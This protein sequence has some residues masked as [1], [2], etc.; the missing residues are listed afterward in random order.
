MAVQPI[1]PDLSLVDFDR[2]PLDAVAFTKLV[3]FSERD[4]EIT[5][6]LGLWVSELE[7]QIIYGPLMKLRGLGYA[8]Q[9]VL[10]A[11]K[12]SSIC[13]MPV[14]FVSKMA[15]KYGDGL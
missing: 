3:F 9:I 5:R 4:R 6:L 13:R 11:Q 14:S 1:P 7:P 2:I 10:A 15:R 12:P 8:D